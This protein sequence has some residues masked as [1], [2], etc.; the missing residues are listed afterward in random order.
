M[1]D[2]GR[3]A[4]TAGMRLHRD[5]PSLVTAVQW[6]RVPW[7]TPPLGLPTFAS[8]SIWDEHPQY[9]PLGEIAG[10][11]QWANG[12]PPPGQP[13]VPPAPVGTPEEW[14]TGLPPPGP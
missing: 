11:R 2:V 3:S 12:A 6:Y 4:Y 8:S 1:V 13:P 9:P 5:D 14:L 10:T 7:N